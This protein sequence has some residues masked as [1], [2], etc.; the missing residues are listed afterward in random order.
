VEAC[1]F[2]DN[3]SLSRS[4]SWDATD[5]QGLKKVA[6]YLR[7]NFSIHPEDHDKWNSIL[8]LYLVRNCFVHASGDI[9]LMKT[10]KQ[11]TKLRN[12]LPMLSRF[13]VY[14]SDPGKISFEETSVSLAVQA[15]EEWAKAFWIASRENAILGPKFWP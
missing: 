7:D 8:G 11:K 2:L 6:N 15:M 4:I 12:I 14:L 5:D 9:Q 10:E 13:G 3:N 1:K